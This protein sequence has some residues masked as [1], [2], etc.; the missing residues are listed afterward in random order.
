[1]HVNAMESNGD[2]E[3]RTQDVLACLAAPSRYRLLLAI[4]GADLCVGELAISVGLSQSCT[5]RHLQVLER[6]GLVEGRRAGRRVNF[7]LRAEAAGAQPILDLVLGGVGMA[8]G[9]GPDDAKPGA[10]ADPA[11]RRHSGGTRRAKLL[12]KGPFVGGSGEAAIRREEGARA[13]VHPPDEEPSSAPEAPARP[14]RRPD[15]EDYLL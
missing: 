10:P 13:P 9:P 4:A 2:M 7:R 15:I 12:Q 1:M 8:L 11:A 6:A 3:S 5:T 14:F